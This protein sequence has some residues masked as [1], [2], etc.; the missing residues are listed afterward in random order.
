M[1]TIVGLG[2]EEYP[3]FDLLVCNEGGFGRIT[4]N[5]NLGGVGQSN[6]GREQAKVIPPWRPQYSFKV[7]L[8]HNY[9]PVSFQ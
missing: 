3:L 9:T 2:Q 1:I 5:V 8:A 4:K 6:F 7:I